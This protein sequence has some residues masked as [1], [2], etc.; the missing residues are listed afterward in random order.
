MEYLAQL[1]VTMYSMALPVTA[2]DS[3]V[4]VLF[5]TK[6]L[7][8]SS[9]RAAL[10]AGKCAGAQRQ[11]CCGTAAAA[12]CGSSQTADVSFVG[13][14]SNAF[15]TAVFAILVSICVKQAAELLPLA[16]TPSPMPLLA[17]TTTARPFSA[18]RLPIVTCKTP[19][20]S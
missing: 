9:A 13:H 10:C 15:Q 18:P 14:V 1:Q 8:S 7:L 11:W 6:E 20:S 17:P 2:P 5:D 4:F 19:S 16:L 3:S 12:N